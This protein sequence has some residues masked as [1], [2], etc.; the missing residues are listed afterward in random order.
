MA[1][2]HRFGQTEKTSGPEE[3]LSET[4]RLGW[5]GEDLKRIVLFV[6][7]WNR[8]IAVIDHWRRGKSHK[9]MEVKLNK[10]S[11]SFLTTLALCDQQTKYV[12]LTS[13]VHLYSTKHTYDTTAYPVTDNSPIIKSQ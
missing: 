6:T 4:N 7:C 9:Y 12:V 5:N 1:M 8:C 11:T 13:L 2:S 10:S 3:W